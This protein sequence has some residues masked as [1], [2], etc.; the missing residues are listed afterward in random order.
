MRW[1]IAGPEGIG[2]ATLAYRL[3]RYLLASP[4][5][6]A[7]SPRAGARR[8][9]DTTAAR[10]VA[11]AVASRPAG[12]PPPLGPQGQ[13]LLGLDPGRRGAPPAR[14]LSW[15]AEEGGRRV[16]IVDT[17]DELN[18]NAA[19][20]LLKSLEE[21]P[22]ARL[23][24][25]VIVGARAACCRP[26]ARAAALVWICG[27]RRAA[28]CAAR[29]RPRSMTSR[30]R[31]PDANDWRGS[32]RLAQRQRAPAAGRW[33]RCATASSCLCS[34]SK[35]WSFAGC[36]GSTGHWSTPS[37]TSW[38]LGRRRAEVRDLLRAAARYAGAA[39]ARHGDRRRADEPALAARLIRP[40]AGL[41]HG[42]S[43]GKHSSARRPRPWLSISTARP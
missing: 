31:P 7:R 38:G 19:N 3:A 25:L 34:A 21:P 15:R 5:R 9:G 29:R 40:A 6:R 39:R 35:A 23:F 17:A 42:P 20:A 26:S 18:V 43:C 8:R 22:P 4:I 2:K 13:A 37:A 32:S 24:L 30:A 33:R 10:Q 16:V 27:A 36:R 41:P 28:T 1:L 14:F 11:G 12:H